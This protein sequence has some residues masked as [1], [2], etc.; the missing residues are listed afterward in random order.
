MADMSLQDP[1]GQPPEFPADPFA[2]ATTDGAG[3]QAPS[4]TP[5]ANPRRAVVGVLVAAVGVLAIVVAVLLGQSMSRGSGITTAGP[6]PGANPAAPGAAPT[7]APTTPAANAGAPAAPA[8]PGAGKPAT[9][10]AVP[11]GTGPVP[12]GATGFGGPLVLNPN[13]PAGVPALDLFEDPQC[14]ICQ[15]FETFFG[16]S[17]GELAK[18]NE[19][20]VVVHTMTFLDRNLHNDSSVRAANGAF[21]A[22]DQG[23]FRD[24]M[25]ATYAAQP[26]QEGIGWTDAQ[27]GVIAQSVGLTGSALDTWKTCQQGLTYAAHIAALETNSERSGVHGTPTALLN[28][29]SMNLSGLDAAGF[30]TA[31]KAGTA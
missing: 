10:T 6:G 20:K 21:C 29:K 2:G 9:P 26:T 13:A 19:A 17:I 4:A 3:S 28:G 18:N 14:P 7:A 1:L 15:Q 30:R 16:A 24:Y 5:Q 25:S 31:V 27:L 11:A 23:K 8:T 22:A 12:A